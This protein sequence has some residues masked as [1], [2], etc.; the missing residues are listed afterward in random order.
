MIN[1]LTK[2]TTLLLFC[3]NANM[4][5]AQVAIEWQKCLG[6]SGTDQV[7]SFQKASD[8]GYI[9]AGFSNS[10]DGN[11]TVNIG[12]GDYWIVK[13]DKDG[14]IHWQKNFGGTNVDYAKSIRQT[15]DDGYIIAG[16][17]HSN[18]GNVSGN[19]GLS[20]YWVLKIDS[21]GLIQW[22]KSLGGTD[23]D[24]VKDITQ[25]SDGGY[26]IAGYTASDNGDVS[27]NH[28]GK[29]FW[30]VKLDNSGNIQWQKCLGGSSGDYA[31]SVQQTSDGGYVI[32]GY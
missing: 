25:T 14:N 29:D 8:E 4:L 23:Y 16:D 28:G 15:F 6:G 24:N 17:S 9:V 12:G 5:Q 21:I 2:I 27:G 10:V 31:L 13:L 30:I 7:N 32:A 19:H 20:D 22:Q 18:D 1:Y 11:I 26:V 3:V